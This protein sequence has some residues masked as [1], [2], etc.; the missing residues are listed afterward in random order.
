MVHIDSA[1]T[2]HI[3]SLQS[4]SFHTTSSLQKKNVLL[5]RDQLSKDVMQVYCKNDIF[6]FF[7]PLNNIVFNSFW[8]CVTFFLCESRDGHISPL[9]YRWRYSWRFSFLFFW[10]RWP[11]IDKVVVY[12]FFFKFLTGCKIISYLV[13]SDYVWW[14]FLKNKLLNM[15]F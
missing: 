6:F 2:V 8:N 1:Y 12:Q 13:Y 7:K 14:K 15:E 3:L 10:Y 4:H 5:F 9:R 11:L